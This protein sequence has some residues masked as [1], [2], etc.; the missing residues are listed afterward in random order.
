MLKT[1][2]ASIKEVRFV[3]QSSLIAVNGFGIANGKMKLKFLQ[4]PF[5]CAL[6]FILSDEAR[7][8]DLDLARFAT[9]KQNQIR[10]YAQTLTNKVPTIVWRYFDM[11]RVDDWENATNLAGRID[12]ASGRYTNSIT[13]ESISPALRTVIW[14]PIQEMIG[15]YDQF[16]DWDNKWLHRFGS[17]IINSI[18]EESI[19]FG[20]T[21]PGRFIISAL[22]EAH[23]DGKHFFV[24]T[25]NQLVDQ[26]YL[27][28]LRRKYDK[29]IYIP[30]LEDM[31]NAFKEYTANASQRYAHDQLK[32]GENV[33][34]LPDGSVQVSGAVAVMQI[35]GLL[36]K[37]IFD[38]NPGHEFYVEESF[39]LDWMYPY[40]SPHGLI[41]QLNAKPLAELSGADIQKD[42]DYWKQLAGELIGDWL[43]DNTSIKEEC[44]FVDKVY[45]DKNLKDFKG[46]M[47]F[48]HNQQTQKTFSKLR[49]SLAGM[50]A[51]RAEH[52]RD[53]DERSRMQRAADLAF[54][55]AYAICPYSPEAIFRYVDFLSKM[56]RP[57]DA[58]LIAKTS[59]RLEPND[60]QFQQL[61]EQVRKQ[62]E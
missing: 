46:D 57:D 49:S 41:F 26:A 43:A 13:D 12:R 19:Y 34:T 28:Y 24:L 55:Q 7:A 1:N 2:H 17:E 48:A 47:G 61:V 9:A 35:N 22:T 23:D 56:K 50:Y 62:S 32:P 33:R 53:D 21:D 60:P 51:W 27:E 44:D 14:P 54:R 31:Q 11:V 45:L 4:I 16:H 5:F 25:Q 59:L 15:T 52:A 30:T 39:P 37:I 6:V 18:P 20:G 38:K 42:Q 29:K 40:L 3:S 36:A 10:E 58:F 8:V